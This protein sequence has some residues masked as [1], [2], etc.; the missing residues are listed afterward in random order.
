[1]GS[2]P[3]LRLQASAILN[4]ITTEAKGQHD[5]VVLACMPE[6]LKA[7]DD[8]RDRVQA[9][10]LFA[11]ANIAGGPP[12]LVR[13]TLM[14]KAVSGNGRV[15]GLAAMALLRSRRIEQRSRTR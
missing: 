2:D 5:D 14:K 12:P 6:M 4:L 10:V 9:N 15:N 7:A 1:V 13:P 8:D 3:H 11:M